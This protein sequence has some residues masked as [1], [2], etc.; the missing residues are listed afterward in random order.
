MFMHRIT[1]RNILSFG[2]DAHELSLEPLNVFIG[3]NGSGK[4]NL[5]DVIRLLQAAP[6]DLAAPIRGSGG[7]ADWIW[8]G[9]PKARSARVDVVVANPAGPQSLRY[10]FEFTE[11]GQSFLM[12][13]ER[14]GEEAPASGGA[15]P[16]TCFEADSQDVTVYRGKADDIGSKLPGINF[17]G[18]ESVLALLKDPDIHPEITGLGQMFGRTRLYRDLQ[19]GRDAP[20]R[21]PQKPDSPHNVLTEDARNLGLVLNRLSRSFDVRQR[22]LE[23]LRSLYAGLS[24]FRVNIEHGA[25]RV[26]I[27]E[28]NVSIPATRLSD[29]TLRYLCL[30]A[31]LCDPDPPPLVCIEE[32]ELGLHPDI[33]PDLAALLRDASERCQLLVT[34]HSD[35]LVDGLTETPESVVVCEKHDG[36]TRMKR[37]NG[38]GLSEWLARAGESDFMVLLVDS[39]A[40]VVDGGTPWTH[41]REHDNWNGPG[42]T[43]PR[44]N[45]RTLWCSAWKRGFLRTRVRWRGSSATD[46]TE[47]RCHAAP[48]SRTSRARSG[49]RTESGD[50]PVQQ[51][52]VPQGASL[53]R[54][55]RRGGPGQGGCGVASCEAAHRH[56]ARQVFLKGTNRCDSF[57]DSACPDCCRFRPTWISSTCSR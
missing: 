30:L 57:S 49:T 37:L 38:D 16:G 50:A 36:R 20:M 5:L 15:T 6:N 43:E 55:S 26:F 33:L 39:E 34:T 24:D 31:V 45:M 25:V 9:E 35:T 54:D 44:N 32:P 23:A 53:V 51:G 7:V 19:V 46:S 22:F 42:R 56:A 48:T 1:L 4:S 47:V 18:H 10:G 3:P 2:P 28:G 12:L 8:G 40:P 21:F 27:Q 17:A 14:L 11:Q 29:G 13:N 41:L 52:G